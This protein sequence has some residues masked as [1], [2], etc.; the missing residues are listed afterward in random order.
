M[1]TANPLRILLVEDDGHIARLI[2]ISMRDLGVPYH[3]DQAISAEEALEL[4]ARQPYDLLLTDHNLRSI[5][6]L[7]LITTLKQRG[8]NT[9]MV[10]FTAY[11][12][13]QLRREA[14]NAGVAAF[15]AKPFFLDLFVDLAR[16]LLPARSSELGGHSALPGTETVQS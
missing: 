10:L 12:T 5:S 9:P 4:W 7:A 13:P 16:S 3:L 11:D 6:G 1:T 8:F 15:I 14:R 2:E